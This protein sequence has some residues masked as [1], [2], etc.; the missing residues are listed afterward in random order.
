MLKDSRTSKKS[1]SLSSEVSNGD[2]YECGL[3][4]ENE[5]A[6][7]SANTT[8]SS[9]PHEPAIDYDER[10]QPAMSSFNGT[11]KPTG[12]NSLVMMMMMGTAN[13]TGPASQQS[14]SPLT[15][16]QIKQRNT[17][18][19]NSIPRSTSSGSAIGTANAAGS[20]DDDLSFLQAQKFD[21]EFLL[22][23]KELFQRF[24]NAKISISVT[25]SPLQADTKAATS[26]QRQIEID[27]HMFERLCASS[28]VNMPTAVSSAKVQPK[29][30]IRTTSV[31]TSNIVPGQPSSV[32]INGIQNS[33]SSTASSSF[34]LSVLVSPEF[35]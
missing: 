33:A 6:Q 8:T 10:Q 28:S 4:Q 15:P 9:S 12:S 18:K 5:T 35:S 20:L 2:V 13:K 32:G 25:L 30:P 7:L 3:D 19:R 29:A 23:T 17:A 34:S 11:A 26:Q 24:P 22:T 16:R 27:R 31:L 14:P 1:G 21:A